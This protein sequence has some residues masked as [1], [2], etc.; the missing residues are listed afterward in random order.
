MTTIV[1]QGEPAECGLACLSMLSEHSKKYISLSELRNFIKPSVF[2]TSFLDLIETSDKVG[3][4]LKAVEYCVDDLNHISVPAILHLEQGHFVILNKVNNNCV[5]I[6][7]PALGKQVLDIQQILPLLTGYA[8][9]LRENVKVGSVEKSDNKNSVSFFKRLDFYIIFLSFFSSFAVFAVP[10]FGIIRQDSFLT[11]NEIPWDTVLYILLFAILSLILSYYLGKRTIQL[12]QK[13]EYNEYS[14]NLNLLFNN[15]LSFFSNRH[16]SDFIN[17]LHSYVNVNVRKSVFYNEILVSA[18]MAV[19]TISV[20]LY[21]N[22]WAALIF[23]TFTFLTIFVTFLEKSREEEFH[24]LDFDRE[25]KKERFLLDCSQSISDIKSMNANNQIISK[26]KVMVKSTLEVDRKK[27]F[28][29]F[30]FSS[31]KSI[32]SSLENVIV[33]I[34]L[35]HSVKQDGVPLTFAFS[36]IFIKGTASSSLASLVSLYLES[37]LFKVTEQKAADFIEYKKDEQQLFNFDFNTISLTDL[38]YNHFISTKTQSATNTRNIY[39][40]DILIKANESTLLTGSSGTGK[41]TL[42][43]ILSGENEIDCEN[44]FIDS[45]VCTSTMLRSLSYYHCNSQRLIDGSLID[46][47]TLFTDFI[48]SELVNYWVNYFDLDKVV[49]SLPDGLLT[50]V[51]ETNNPLSSGEKQKLLLIRAMISRKPI[52]LLDEPTSNLNSKDSVEVLNK[53][54]NSKRTVVISSHN[55]VRL[56]NF[57]NIIELKK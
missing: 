34:L 57:D 38:K 5:E 31:I 36:F 19:F 26:F 24:N 42:L 13:S 4:N 25:E 2:G 39:F 22:W 56:E 10:Y 17:R 20:L 52:L 49:N 11:G 7:N 47:L 45:E 32:F 30:G 50:K 28:V 14:I 15:H 9:I 21:I 44:A 3:I 29:N 35:F 46:N 55:K 27:F 48:P 37:S 12:S 54:L 1:Y 33:L 18:V 16:P 23:L 6:L 8:L 43:K 51:S 40:P 53:I 41:T